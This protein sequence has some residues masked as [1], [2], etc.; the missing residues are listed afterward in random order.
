MFNK[1]LIALFLI[2]HSSLSFA[3]PE[4]AVFVDTA[5][6]KGGFLEK[7]YKPEGLKEIKAKIENTLKNE[8]DS[9]YFIIENDDYSFVSIINTYVRDEGK[10]RGNE[11]SYSRRENSIN[12]SSEKMKG[13]SIDERAESCYFSEQEFSTVLADVGTVPVE[14]A[15]ELIEMTRSWGQ[16]YNAPVTAFKLLETHPEIDKQVKSYV[17]VF[18]TMKLYL[19]VQEL[20]I[21]K[22]GYTRN[23]SE[24]TGWLKHETS[25][26]DVEGLKLLGAIDLLKSENKLFLSENVICSGEKQLRGIVSRSAEAED[27]RPSHLMFEHLDNFFDKMK[28][29]GYSYDETMN[30]WKKN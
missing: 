5:G 8:E 22:A 15:D 13:M 29:T 20:V 12:C 19:Y 26:V 30:I 10:W 28:E 6:K 2:A 9:V 27:C 1:N 11:A 25:Q 21:K 18:R 7:L 23:L 14:N 24:P 4:Q 3:T 17:D 16:S